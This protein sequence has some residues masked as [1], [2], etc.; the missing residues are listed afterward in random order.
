MK[1]VKNI[2]RRQVQLHI[3]Q[4][5]WTRGKTSSPPEGFIIDRRLIRQ[6]FDFW[7]QHAAIAYNPKR[8]ASELEQWLHSSLL[9]HAQPGRLACQIGV[10]VFLSFNQLCQNTADLNLIIFKKP[11]WR[12]KP[13]LHNVRPNA[14][15]TSSFQ[16]LQRKRVGEDLVT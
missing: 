6:F 14:I 7:P 8:S 3:L 11:N 13:R 5:N 2:V 1:I 12:K 9:Q 16:N 10:S 15:L 4:V